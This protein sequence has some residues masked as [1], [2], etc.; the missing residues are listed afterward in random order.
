MSTGGYVPEGF[1]TV[2]P[3][4]VVRGVA[5]LIEFLTQA[6]G[7]EE[8]LRVTRDDG[9][10]R[11]AQVRIGDSMVELG[12][13]ESGTSMP[14]VLHLYVPDVDATYRRALTAGATSLREP[15]DQDF[16]ERHA[17]VADPSG[18]HWYIATH[19]APRPRRPQG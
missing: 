11:H 7:A 12:E 9:S 3:Y 10:I 19:K 2:T 17:A 4:L 14:G 15:A 18:N 16:G 1:H 6:F 13:A 8:V 5:R